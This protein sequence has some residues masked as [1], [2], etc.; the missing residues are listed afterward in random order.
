M[1]A[2][3]DDNRGSH[4]VEPICNV[5]PIAP[6][7]YH[8]HVAER[9]DPSRLSARARRDLALKP[10]V[11]YNVSTDSIKGSNSI[12]GDNVPVGRELILPPK[13]RSGI[14]YKV[15]SGDSV[16]KLAERYKTTPE[17]ITR[18]NDLEATTELT[19]DELI[20]L[21]DAEKL[22]DP[23]IVRSTPS[24][25]FAPSTTAFIPQLT[26][27]NGYSYGWCTYWAAGRRIETG[28]PIPSNW[29]NANTWDDYA[30]ASGY[31][32]DNIPSAGAVF[33]TDGYGHTIYH[34]AYV[35]SVN[36][37]GS[38]VISEMNYRGWNVAS[39]RV[40]SPSEASK[41]NYIH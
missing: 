7:T 23:V 28:N 20:F 41:Y 38:V 4:G 6:S 39:T 24:S 1:I 9:R 34:V 31:S 17:K 13:N 33:Q 22:P 32:V 2:F 14:V 16:E 37:D 19:N 27:G 30:R 5:L 3:I 10:E 35:E 26:A 18:F 29:G 15:A 12:T 11:E 36:D 25:T 8:K 21:P 40:I